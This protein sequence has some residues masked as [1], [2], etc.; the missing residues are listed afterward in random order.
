MVKRI[1]LLLGF[2]AL[3]TTVLFSQSLLV[4]N[5][6][7]LSQETIKYCEAKLLDL[8]SKA[9]TQ[10]AIIIVPSL[11][12]KT[13]EAYA[14]DYFDYNGYG[15]GDEREGVLLL[16]STGDG[17]PGSGDMHISTHGNKTISK[18]TDRTID[19]LLDTLYDRGLKLRNYDSAV[20]AYVERLAFKLHNDVS[21]ND[22]LTG[23]GGGIITFLLSFFGIKR[24]NKVKA[25]TMA[26]KSSNYV[27]ADFAPFNDAI[28][29]TKV[30]S[31]IIQRSESGRGGSGSSTHTSS[32]GSTHGGGG[33][34][35]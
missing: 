14:D 8:Q 19:D 29:D 2:F 34:S 3:S 4:D 11:E 18:L 12:G 28:I 22:V 31:H 1:L 24:R 32:S 10:A 35:F 16:I 13:R 6:G 15:Y 21:G 5:V 9:K 33:R 23:V 26:Y 27:I 17:T 25:A 30:T 20:K 7:V